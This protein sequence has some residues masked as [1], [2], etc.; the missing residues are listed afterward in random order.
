MISIVLPVRGTPEMLSVCLTAIGQSLAGHSTDVEAILL[1]DASEEPAVLEV[2]REWWPGFP[3]Q[4]WRARER[5]HWLGSISFGTQ[6][7]YGDIL[8]WQ[9]DQ[10]MAPTTLPALAQGLAE[11]EEDGVWAVRT[12]SNQVDD[13]E[14]TP[15][16]IRP[17]IPIQHLHQAFSFSRYV[18][19]SLGTQRVPAAPI[20]SD[21]VLVSRRAIDRV[22]VLD[23]AFWGYF[24][25]VDY[26]CRVLRAGGKL[27]TVLGA[28]AYH[29]GWIHIKGEAAKDGNDEA[30]FKRAKAQRMTWVQAAYAGWRAK[31][32][33]DALPEEYPG[34]LPPEAFEACKH[35]PGPP[36]REWPDLERYWERVQ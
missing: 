26:W 23:P 1:D 31:W 12:S 33:L 32:G 35:N 6:I 21:G 15:A 4:V 7:G 25:D 22:G 11:G 36:V 27:E 13:G 18:Y 9:C 28:W 34:I 5:Q 8:W 20:T 10:L 2:M 30:A 29:D 17:P 3:T 19:D 14:T 16:T 24:G